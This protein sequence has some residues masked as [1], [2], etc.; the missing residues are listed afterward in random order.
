MI[1][2][3]IRCNSGSGDEESLS[4]AGRE[5]RAAEHHCWRHI[6]AGGRNRRRIYGTAGH[7]NQFSKAKAVTLMMRIEFADKINRKKLS[8]NLKHRI[9]YRQPEAPRTLSFLRHPE[10]S[11][12]QGRHV[13]AGRCFS[14]YLGPCRS[15]LLPVDHPR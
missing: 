9:F 6:R 4:R 5:N 11:N 10:A 2:A 3:S 14:S 15:A 8:L 12:S 1:A 7:L 13:W